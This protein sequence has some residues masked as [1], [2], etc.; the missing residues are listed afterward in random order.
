M[1]QFFS[2]LQFTTI[3]VLFLAL[4]IINV[5]L[6][7]SPILGGPLLI[8]YVGFFG[9]RLGGAIVPGES[10]LPR[11]WAGAWVL[12]SALML[13]GAIFYYLFPVSRDFFVTLVLLTPPLVHWI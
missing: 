5:F 8:F 6:I 10:R 2:S 13:L 12:L 4:F 11:L 1:L 7:N 9:L 3:S